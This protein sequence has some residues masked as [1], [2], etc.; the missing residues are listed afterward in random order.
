MKLAAVLKKSLALVLV[1]CICMS[2][3]TLS[4]FAAEADPGIVDGSTSTGA[5]SGT[6]DCQEDTPT[7]EDD[8]PSGIDPIYESNPDTNILPSNEECICDT[9]CTE[10]E[11]NVNCPVC[12]AVDADLTNCIGTK[13]SHAGD[14]TSEG[15]TCLIKCTEE[16]INEDCPVCSATDAD[17]NDCI[18]KEGPGIIT[19]GAKTAGKY[20]V[21]EGK[22]ITFS[23]EWLNGKINEAFGQASEI[24]VSKCGYQYIQFSSRYFNAELLIE[25]GAFKGIKITGIKVYSYGVMYA[26]L[27]FDYVPFDASTGEYGNHY[28]IN[29][30][31]ATVY[32]YENDG[33]GSLFGTNN[34]PASQGDASGDYFYGTAYAGYERLYVNRLGYGYP[35]VLTALVDMEKYS[36][37]SWLPDQSDAAGHMSSWTADGTH[38]FEVAY[39]AD[40]DTVTS[41]SSTEYEIAHIK[42]LDDVFDSRE[43]ERLQAIIEHAYPFITEEQMLNEM[44]AKN[45]TLNSA[46]QPYASELMMIATQ[47]SIWAITN[48]GTPDAKVDIQGIHT[49]G[50]GVDILNNDFTITTYEFTPDDCINNTTQQLVSPGSLFG[51]SLTPFYNDINKI[52]NYLNTCDSSLV[53]PVLT[54][55]WSFDGSE[56]TA[57]G[58]VTGAKVGDSIQL[59]VGD[60]TASLAIGN[61][62][63]PFA[64]TL[65][66][67]AKHGQ[68]AT[69]TVKGTRGKTVEA[70]YFESDEYQNFIGGQ[71]HDVEVSAQS[72]YIIPEP[73]PIRLQV[74]KEW[75]DSNRNSMSAPD[76]ASITVTLLISGEP[77][78]KTLTLNADNNWTGTFEN[79]SVVDND[80]NTIEYSVIEEAYTGFDPEYS[81]IETSEDGTFSIKI[82]NIQQLGELTIRKVLGEDAPEA[83]YSKT[84]SFTVTGPGGYSEKVEITGEDSKTLKNL[85]PGTYTVTEDKENAVIDG[86]TLEV[87]GETVDTGV[88]VIGK[89]KAVE[90]EE[91]A[92]YEPATVQIT[93]TY[94]KELGSLKI[95]KVVDG[96]GS[97]AASKTYR[98]DITGPDGYSN[99]VTITGAS[100]TTITGLV[101][102]IYTITEQNAT[103]EGYNLVVSG[104][105]TV[106]VEAEETA[107]ATISNIYTE[108]PGSL[109]ITKVVNGGG[110][111]AATKTYTFTVTGPNGYNTTVN[112]TG[113]GSQTLE[114]LAPGTYTIAEQDA[115]IEGYTLEVTGNTTATVTR[116]G[117]AQVTITNTY[118]QD[119]GS[120]TIRK[121]VE[122]LTAAE[123]RNLTFTF[124]VTGPDGYNQEVNVAANASV[125]LD[126]LIPGQ[127]TVT[128]SSANVNGYTWSARGGGSVTVVADQNTTVTITNDYEPQATPT[129]P[130]TSTPTNPPEESTPPQTPAPTPAPTPV[131]TPAPTPAPTPVTPPQQDNP[132]PENNDTPNEPQTP[133]EPNTPEDNPNQDVPNQDVPQNEAPNPP[134]NNPNE[135]LPNQDTPLDNGPNLPDAPQDEPGVD[136]P[137]DDVPQ[138]DFPPVTGETILTLIWVVLLICSGAGMLVTMRSN[139]RN[140]N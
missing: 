11:V 140:E 52:I 136:L 88:E 86:W 16:C 46:L 8:S 138:S 67:P 22:S 4:V 114:D 137:D 119:T 54:V 82:S 91:V 89:K 128:E 126:D 129:P 81:E 100:S 62:D 15:C 49:K 104:N 84:Y 87:T 107:E 63:D 2:F 113:N 124:R 6:P 58:T 3:M 115:T 96:G 64:F 30:N 25:D 112:I 39:C 10:E 93:N 132:P 17:L 139:K 26:P 109:T 83:A 35:I 99:T 31:I 55:N 103:I 131:P 14:K 95:T 105:A 28:C 43:Q 127:Y 12:G 18:G 13:P 41:D 66:A 120:L 5:K 69:L 34:I 78:G 29:I 85:V 47:F 38:N 97:E 116:D 118:T 32:D 73:E 56:V 50:F 90:G 134:E 72:E 44:S 20:G 71:L 42:G 59:T 37:S 117:A 9:K 68:T 45:I 65:S 21:Y 98:F 7:S 19:T 51:Y 77:S 60:S 108:K 1:L 101:P 133:N 92:E 80:G 40:S 110:N 79:L 121:V 75:L 102:G 24:D 53:D 106:T 123:M 27:Y 70:M 94:T 33:S 111:D 122:G 36:G 48:P 57:T 23:V 125:T 135:D 74:T 130:P 76:D 61:S